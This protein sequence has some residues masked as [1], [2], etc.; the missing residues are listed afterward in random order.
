MASGSLKL[1]EFIQTL[2]RVPKLV[3]LDIGA[4]GGTKKYSE[5]SDI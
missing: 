5:I 1:K 4:F 2:K 3:V